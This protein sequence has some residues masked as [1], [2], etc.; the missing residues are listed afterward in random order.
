MS[1]QRNE[2][3]PHT[4]A[5]DTPRSLALRILSRQE[6]GAY[7]NL[8]LDH[9]LERSSLSAPDRALCTALVMGT[10]QWQVSLDAIIAR[11]SSRPLS[12]LD[13]DVLRALRLGLFQLRYLDRV[14]D[15]AAVDETV[16]AAPRDARGYVNAILRTYLR[17]KDTMTFADT[18]FEK[19]SFDTGMPMPLCARFTAIFGDRAAAVLTAFNRR[20]P[21]SLRVNTLKITRDDFIQKLQDAGYDAA[22]CELCDTAVTL[23]ECNVTA[24]P[25]FDTGLFFV[26]DV[27]SQ[28]CT[29]AVCAQPGMR[30]VDFCACP[31]SKSFGMAIDMKNEGNLLSCDL[32]RNKLSLVESGA[33]RLGITNLTTQEHDGRI[34][35]DGENRLFDR[36]LCDVPCSGFGVL[37]K[38]PEIRHK[39]LDECAG[40]PAIQAA[41]LE[42]A[43][44]HLAPGG[45]LV[46]STCT[47]LPEENGD[48]VNAFLARHPE[49]TLCTAKAGNVEIPGMMTL[50]PDLYPTDGFFIAVLEKQ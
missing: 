27:A 18:P 28:L 6:D 4:P 49:Y 31:G 50:T 19:L 44:G 3:P 30:V 5:T 14:P 20:P 21:L 11:L 38:K 41:I 33:V 22:P 36:I 23:P 26:Q 15:H 40:L 45:R 48:V 25:G 39:D 10:I 35:L 37:G 32:H 47:L 29:A 42:N 9:A 13:G 12:A 24:L 7:A 43:A 8:A 2:K 34:P 17:E 46:Y 16:S 1:H